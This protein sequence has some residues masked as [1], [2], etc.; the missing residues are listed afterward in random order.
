MPPEMPTVPD[1]AVMRLGDL[2]DIALVDS[3]L[4]APHP[5]TVT[6]LANASPHGARAVGLARGE[7][8]TVGGAKYEKYFGYG[9]V[10]WCA[11][12]VSWAVDVTGNRDHRAPWSNP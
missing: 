4:S 7:Y 11:L 1:Q 5:E 2:I 8:G 10:N 6:F 9:T 3:L 12:F